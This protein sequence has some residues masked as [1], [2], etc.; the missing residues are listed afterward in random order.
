M[1]IRRGGLSWQRSR[2]RPRA[3]AR[4]PS[5]AV[6]S[7]RLYGPASARPPPP[8][9]LRLLLALARDLLDTEL[10]VEA[11][12]AAALAAAADRGGAE[13]V[14]PDRYADMGVGRGDAVRRV[15]ADPAELRHLGLGPG[16]AGAL[17]DDPVCAD[18]VS[19]DVAGRDLH[20]A[21]GR[22]EDV[23]EILADAPAHG[24]GLARR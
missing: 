10:H 5:C 7:T 17:V 21:A 13:I 20:P 4:K 23:R 18:E 22:D 6:G 8:S 2:T 15:E 9:A 12:R 14:E 3:G 16:M 1:R 11:F 24:E 19:G